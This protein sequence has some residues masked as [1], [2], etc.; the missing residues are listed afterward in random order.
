MF[1][2]RGFWRWAGLGAC[3]VMAVAPLHPARG[4]GLAPARVVVN[5]RA[6]TSDVPP[7]VEQHRVLV[8][9]RAVFTALGAYVDFDARTKTVIVAQP[10]TT[11]ELRVFSQRA[12]V[13]GNTVWL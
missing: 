3:L 7:L 9:I 13:N 6:V 8:P 1:H 5:G 2:V 4:A 11:I 12:D 10:K